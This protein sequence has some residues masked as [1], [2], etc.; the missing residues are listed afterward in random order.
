MKLMARKL[1]MKKGMSFLMTAYI[2]HRVELT[3]EMRTIGKLMYLLSCS[4]ITNGIYP[5]VDK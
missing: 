5:R 3:S 1:V 4:L 2:V